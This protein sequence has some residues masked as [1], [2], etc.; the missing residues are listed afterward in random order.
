MYETNQQ[1]LPKKYGKD[2]TLLQLFLLWNVTS[3]EGSKQQRDEKSKVCLV[4]IVFWILKPM[5]KW[6]SGKSVTS[7]LTCL[8]SVAWISGKVEKK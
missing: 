2:K 8:A 6:K 5:G 7:V 3:S 1:Y 4:G